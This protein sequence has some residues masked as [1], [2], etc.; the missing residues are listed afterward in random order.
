MW[1]RNP[2]HLKEQEGQND[3][4]IDACVEQDDEM[5]AEGGQK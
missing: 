4:S 2:L 1:E 3:S 5:G